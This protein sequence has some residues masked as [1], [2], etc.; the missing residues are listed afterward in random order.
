MFKS[1]DTLPEGYSLLGE[2]N[3]KDNKMEFLFLNIGAIVMFIVVMFAWVGII[4]PLTVSEPL[5]MLVLMVLFVVNIIIHEWIHAI[6]FKRGNDVKVTFKFHGFA[7]SAS[8]PGR[9]FSKKQY[10]ITGMAPFVI[11]T[12]VYA[13]VAWFAYLYLTTSYQAVTAFLMAIHISGCMGDF[14]VTAKL[15]SKDPSI[16]VEDYGIGMRYF[17][18]KKE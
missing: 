12:I 11:L 13:A 15:M 9:F 5:A 7:A 6:F 10:L 8:V 1:Y 16:L 18:K 4:G 17:S 14:Y 2:I 3:M